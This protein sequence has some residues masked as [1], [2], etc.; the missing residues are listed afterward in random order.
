MAET[1]TAHTEAPG[2]PQK[3]P[4]PPFERDTF[5]SQLFWL[6]ICFIALYLI[7]ARLVQPRVGGIIEARRNR[8]AQ[9]L[10]E[11]TRLKQDSEAALAAYEKALADA[12]ARAQAIA[13]ETRDRLHGEA[14][15]NR[16]VLD[17]QLNIRLTEA[18]RTIEATKRAAM[19]NVRGIAIEA[20]GEIVNRL[21]GVRPAEP[22]VAAAVD[23]VLK[24]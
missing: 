8:I 2:T 14:E 16:K 5:P 7:T 13:G 1:T 6:A 10:A 20:A 24:R 9:D 23:A 19:A 3:A 15:R 18:E 21:A 12:R 22:A 4:F 17:E 11:A